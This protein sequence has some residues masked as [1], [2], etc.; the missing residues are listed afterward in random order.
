MGKGI[1]PK[2]TTL[3]FIIVG[4]ELGLIGR[5]IDAYRTVFFASFAG[6]TKVKRRFHVDILPAITDDF[7]LHHL[8]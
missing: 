2:R 3:P 6:E 7:A 4:Q 8:P 1:V 5:D